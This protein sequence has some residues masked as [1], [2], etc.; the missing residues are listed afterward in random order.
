MEAMEAREAMEAMEARVGT[1]TPLLAS[2]RVY[3]L[4]HL[5]GL[6]GAL[7]WQTHLRNQM[8]LTLRPQQLGQPMYSDWRL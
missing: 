2:T 8:R 5:E 4:M 3:L 1:R 7:A 6:S